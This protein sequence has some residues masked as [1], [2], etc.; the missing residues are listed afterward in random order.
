MLWTCCRPTIFY[1]RV[2]QLVVQQ[3]IEVSGVWLHTCMQ[4]R[5]VQVGVR[6]GSSGV[7]VTQDSATDDAEGHSP[8][9]SSSSVDFA[10]QLSPGVWHQVSLGVHRRHVTLHVDCD[11]T[12]TSAWRR[13]HA[14]TGNAHDD[15]DDDDYGEQ[16]RP[17]SRSIVLSVGKAFIESTRY[18]TFE[19]SSPSL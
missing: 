18:P 15:D 12:M 4:Y 7:S 6:L 11:V 1:G 5:Y 9:S 10:V 13:R 2:L 16:V 19:V 14:A 8:S 17:G 3:Q